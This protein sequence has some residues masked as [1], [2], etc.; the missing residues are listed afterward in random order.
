VAEAGKPKR[1]GGF[2]DFQLLSF[3]PLFVVAAYWSGSEAVLFVV[4]FMF[5]LLLAFQALF[6]QGE[7]TLAPPG[8]D[9]GDRDGLT[10][11]ATRRQALAT[12]SRFLDTERNTGM[13]TAVLHIDIDKFRLVNDRFGME[14]GD[15]ILAEIGQRLKSS[16]READLVARIDGDDFAIVL[17]PIRK[18]DYAIAIGISD[19]IR[20]A[21]TQPFSIDQITCH[22]GC[23]VGICLSGRAPE[24]DAESVLTSAEIAL[25]LARK[26]GPNAT[27]SFSPRMR[28][29]AQKLHVLSAELEAA[30]ENGQIRPWFQ[31]QICAD[32]GEV[33]G[34]E[35]LARWEHP[36]TGV[37]LPD[38][39][40]KAIEST[41]KA[42]RL[43]E[44]ILYHA[45]SAV[46]AWDRAG[47]RV[48][49]V[50]VNFSTE[51]LR[52]P[53][54]V[55]KIKWEVDRFELA[56]A[57]LTIEVLEN[58]VSENDD[59]TVTR[60]IRALAA[61]GF[62]IDLDDFG[63][64]HAAIA[65]IRRFAVSRLKID[66]S[67]VTRIDSDPEQQVLTSAILRMADSLGLAT[68][69][70]GVETP[71]EQARLAALGCRYIQGFGIAKP[72][73]FEDTI[74]WIGQHQDKLARLGPEDRKAG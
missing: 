62:N 23:S 52:N 18:A 67:F 49:S 1:G 32:T 27:R 22:L 15:R 64:G 17:A 71:G 50:G 19:R 69:A 28:R 29:E 70:E 55:E 16:V 20:A 36:E 68:L 31:P 34:F 10:G 58:V 33:A 38:L 30:L 46:R 40:L 51:E 25:E 56:P 21:I 24:Q 44:V 48:P 43:G 12:I 42:G 47:F 9:A 14:A 66:R 26:E 35:A 3:L 41:G 45:L 4:S 60:N 54:L 11:L 2:R 13:E 6:P 72:M 61:Q 37:I 53:K 73:P 63:T 7:V 8:L 59:D 57:R 65:N 74:A 5:P 39:F